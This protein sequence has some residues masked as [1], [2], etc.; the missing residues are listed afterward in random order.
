MY[1]RIMFPMLSA[2]TCIH[3]L[4]SFVFIQ[5]RPPGVMLEYHCKTS[6]CRTNCWLIGS[7]LAQFKFH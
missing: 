3:L 4:H 2:R 6:L 1:E 5:I 7:M